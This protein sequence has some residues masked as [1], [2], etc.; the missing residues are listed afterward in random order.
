MI[1]PYG[2]TSATA[3]PP[4]PQ[5]PK[6]DTGATGPKGDTGAV[7]PK[8]DT[9]ATGAKGDTGATG[10]KGDTGATGAAGVGLSPGIPADKTVAIGTAYQADVSAKVNFLC[11]TV[12]SAYSITVAG[13]Q[14]DELELRIGPDASV[15]S[16]GGYQAGTA[17]WSLTGLAVTI[18][19]GIGDR[20]PMP[21]LLPAG[22]FFAVRRL[23]GTTATIKA[24]K[25]QPLT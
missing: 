8:G 25:L 13:T 6:G 10:P 11:V 20:T 14:S 15:A 9:G 5:G 24:C 2:W 3:G 16:G 18:G 1:I 4:G 23:S 21:I 22:W 12:D 19:M 17:K 7:G